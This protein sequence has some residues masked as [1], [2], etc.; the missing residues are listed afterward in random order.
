MAKKRFNK[1]QNKVLTGILCGAVGLLALGGIGVLTEGFTEFDKDQLFGE[2]ESSRVAI[3]F[4]QTEK[5]GE[6]SLFAYFN[7]EDLETTYQLETNTTGLIASQ[8]VGTDGFDYVTV[9]KDDVYTVEL[10]SLLPLEYDNYNEYLEDGGKCY[11]ILVKDGIVYETYEVEKSG[12]HIVTFD[13]ENIGELDVNVDK[14]LVEETE[15]KE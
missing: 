2:A 11:V 6:V 4:E 15:D 10:T 7:H 3:S 12:N 8:V 13:D 5:D 14:F 9:D 1:K